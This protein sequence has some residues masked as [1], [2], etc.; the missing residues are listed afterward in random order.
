MS[1]SIPKVIHYCWFGKNP[2]PESVEKC[3]ESWKKYCPEYKIICWNEDNFDVSCCDYVREAY[4]AQKWAFVSDVARLMII[5]EHGGIYLDTDV[6]LIKSLDFVV[7]E[8]EFFFGIE[9]QSGDVS[10]IV[11][12]VNTG[13]GFGAIVHNRIVK[14]MLDIYVDLHFETADGVDLTPCPKRNSMVLEKYGFDGQDAKYNF[15]NGTI[16]PSKYF[17]P[18]EY[19][20]DVTY[21]LEMI[22]K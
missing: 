11:S 5:Y 2:L 9:T 12:E 10:S 1:K 21:Y 8:N 4:E 22:K 20:S 13:I 14:E 18:L 3:I 6:E 19:N 16:Y 15:M 7:D 17:C